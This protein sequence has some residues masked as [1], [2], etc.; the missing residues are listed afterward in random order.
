M[1]IKGFHKMKHKKIIKKEPQN[2]SKGDLI[3]IRLEYEEALRAKR[4]IIAS[5]IELLRIARA[6][7]RYSSFRLEELDAKVKLYKLIKSL[8]LNVNNLRAT[9][10][11]I[12]IPDILKKEEESKRDEMPKEDK[13]VKEI[14]KKIEETEEKE[15]SGDLESQLEEIQ[16][17]LS[18]I[19]Q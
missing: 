1:K 14:R 8:K 9:L 11:K 18:A 2:R 17:K 13:G 3:H 10:P 5:K 12:R 4:D 16:R 6:T 15:Y 19:H 7:K